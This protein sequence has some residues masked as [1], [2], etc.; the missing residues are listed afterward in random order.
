MVA[1]RAVQEPGEIFQ[2]NLLE[3]QA[4]MAEP[5]CLALRQAHLLR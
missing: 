5:F 4:V 2:I 1:V 3:V